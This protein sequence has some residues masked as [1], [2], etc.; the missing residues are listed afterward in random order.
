MFDDNIAKKWKEEARARGDTHISENMIDYIVDELRYKAK[1][2]TDV[3][4]VSLYTGDV[5]KSDFA[6][7]VS[8]KNALQGAIKSLENVPTSSKDWHPGS[9]NKVL[10]LVHPSLF[11]FV[12]GVTRVLKKGRLGLDGCVARSGEGITV[13][14]PSEQEAVALGTTV[15]SRSPYS[16]RFQ[17]LPCEVDISG[18]RARYA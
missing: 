4:A 16:R 3:E 11:P 6:V 15:A 5:V 7:D 10:D 8:V 2:F 9:D 1:Y 18:D 12:Y 13:S 17:W 14:V